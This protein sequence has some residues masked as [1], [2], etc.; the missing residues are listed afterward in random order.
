MP[1]TNP[2]TDWNTNPKNPVADDFNRIEGNID[3]LK[4]D[5]ETKK[6]L[7]VDALNSVGIAA[8]IAD[9]HVQIASKITGAKKTGVVITPGTVNQAIPNGIY[10]EGSGVISGDPDLISANIKANANIFGVPGNPNVVDTSPGD[11]TAAQIL[12][13]KKAYVDGALITGNIS[14]KGAATITPGT[15]N[16]QIATGQYLSGIQTIVGSANLKPENIKDGVNIFDKIGSLVPLPAIDTS[17]IHMHAT[18]SS[19]L[20]ES[21]ME[22]LYT[23]A[24]PIT[25]NAMLFALAASQFIKYSI[26]SDR[27]FYYHKGGSSVW[28]AATSYPFSSFGSTGVALIFNP[29]RAT[30]TITG[31]GNRANKI[32]ID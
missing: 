15:V 12:S 27:I 23:A 11:A 4:T 14:S 17:M 2:K 26:S 28:Y 10:G 19:A 5:I 13:G 24:T 18:S 20:S 31:D 16:Q 7:I 32:W 3:F 9:T 21:F 25:T 1:W 8:L 30:L 29:S 6:G 22:T